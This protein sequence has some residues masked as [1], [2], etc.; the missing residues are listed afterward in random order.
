MM[1]LLISAAPQVR[2]V[3]ARR[4]ITGMANVKAILPIVVNER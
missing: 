2:G 4:I 1:V 3:A